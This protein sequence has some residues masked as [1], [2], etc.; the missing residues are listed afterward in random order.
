[1][2]LPTLKRLRTVLK[3]PTPNPGSSPLLLL[4]LQVPPPPASCAHRRLKTEGT[5]PLP[6]R[7][8]SSNTARSEYTV[9][10][11]WRTQVPVTRRNSI[12]ASVGRLPRTLRAFA[13]DCSAFY[14]ISITGAFLVDAES[15]SVR[16]S[17]WIQRG[18]K[19]KTHS[20][21]VP[22]HLLKR[23]TVSFHTNR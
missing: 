21:A 17:N 9:D 3:S 19:G 22:D 16:T 1:M 20:P 10:N 23:Q 11:K 7:F 5:P 14:D 6:S 18:K 12:V 8:I 13:E 2:L 15:S 4:S